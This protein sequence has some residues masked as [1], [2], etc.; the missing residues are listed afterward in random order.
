MI[1]NECN[2]KRLK[3]NFP[4]GKKSKPTIKCKDCKRT[5]TLLELKEIKKRKRE[6]KKGRK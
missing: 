3:K 1:R 5:I 2:H 4:F 6:F